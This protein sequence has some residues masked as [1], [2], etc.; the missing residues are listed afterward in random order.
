LN[1]PFEWSPLPELKSRFVPL[2]LFLLLLCALVCARTPA[3][4]DGHL[5]QLGSR[6]QIIAHRGA[7]PPA[8]A[9]LVCRHLWFG[10][11]PSG[12]SPDWKRLDVCARL[13][14]GQLSRSTRMIYI[15]PDDLYQIGQKT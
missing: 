14:G 8:A 10:A 7:N 15:R 11:L 12:L 13:A 6:L 3:R 2:P 5:T 9:P 4:A 1:Q